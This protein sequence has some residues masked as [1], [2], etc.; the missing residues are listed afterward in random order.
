MRIHKH[1]SR[2]RVRALAHLSCALFLAAAVGAMVGVAVSYGPLDMASRAA[3][4]LVAFPEPCGEL[5][6]TVS[7]ANALLVSFATSASN[8]TLKPWRHA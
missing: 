8:I 3:E 7:Y 5:A 2:Q 1:V 6:Q 4:S